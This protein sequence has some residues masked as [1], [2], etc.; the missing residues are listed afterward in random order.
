MVYV[1]SVRHVATNI[2]SQVIPRLFEDFQMRQREREKRKIVKSVLTLYN[3]FV[4][5]YS[6]MDQFFLK[7]AF[8][9]FYLVHS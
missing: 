9:N 2:S 4:S 6:R 3:V 5:S 1:G 7:A 8:H